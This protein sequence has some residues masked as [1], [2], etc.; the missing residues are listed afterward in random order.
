MEGEAVTETT[1]MLQTKKQAGLAKADILDAFAA[2]LRL[3]VAQGDASPETIRSYHAHV[4][5][6][7]AWCGDHRVNPALATEEDL[8]RYRAYLAGAGYGRGTIAVKLSVVRRLYQ[9]ATWRG[10]RTDN[11]AAGLKAPKERGSRADRVKYLPLAGFRALVDAPDK[12]TAKGKRDRAILTLLGY[13]GLRVS[14]VAGLTV[15]NLHLGDP[16]WITV[17]GKGNK[18]RQVYLTSKTRKTLEIWLA[19]RP[20]GGGHRRVFVALDNRTRGDSLSSRSIRN[21]VDVYLEALGL[22]EPG[23]S[24]HSL[25]HSF[26]TWSL[27]G[28]AK[29]ES[30]QDTL[31]HASVETTQVYAKIVDKMRENPTLYLEKLLSG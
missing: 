18:T 5:Q 7:V 14:E 24:C 20:V 4:G 9:A 11:P 6:F 16:A 21:L 2:F 19:A 8:E 15:D 26:A 13:H 1:A 17:R 29:L 10:L 30:I 3:N 25:R 22:K 12:R 23:I 28:G 31:G 27:A